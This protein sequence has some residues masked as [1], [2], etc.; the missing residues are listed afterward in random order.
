MTFTSETVLRQL[1]ALLPSRPREV[2]GGVIV[3]EISSQSVTVRPFRT[4]LRV[5]HTLETSSSVCTETRTVASPSEVVEMI[6]E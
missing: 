3:G 4:H 2:R 6:F 1:E 5:R